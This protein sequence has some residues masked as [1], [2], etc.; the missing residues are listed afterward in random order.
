VEV[1]RT[2][3]VATLAAEMRADNAGMRRAAEK[4][5]FT[6]LPT[7]TDDVIRAEMRLA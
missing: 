6:I 7:A 3:G 5:G 4:V 1:A 2:E